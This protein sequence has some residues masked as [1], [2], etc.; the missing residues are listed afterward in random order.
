MSTYPPD[1]S[2]ATA[3]DDSK[4]ILLALGA[5]LGLAVG[6]LALF[7][8][9]RGSPRI[10]GRRSRGR[11]TRIPAEADDEEQH[12]LQTRVISLER[13]TLDLQAQLAASHEAQLVMRDA[14]SA[15]LS[16]KLSEV[17]GVVQRELAKEAA[18]RQENLAQLRRQL[19]ESERQHAAKFIPL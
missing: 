2:P 6:G 9:A 12:S 19:D 8:V 15:E 7:A 17:C 11:M 5:L 3:T 13:L 10:L 14:I 18:T 1:P 16:E 4:L